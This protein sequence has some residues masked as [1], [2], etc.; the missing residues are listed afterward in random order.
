M[1]KAI[2]DMTVKIKRKQPATVYPTFNHNVDL[3]LPRG[4]KCKK[5]ALISVVVALC[6]A[7]V[8]QQCLLSCS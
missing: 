4:S 6:I 8:A 5:H 1:L 3:K 7:I 2:T